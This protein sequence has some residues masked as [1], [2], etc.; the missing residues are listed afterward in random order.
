MRKYYQF[1]NAGA[2]NVLVFDWELPAL[3][4]QQL[5]DKIFELLLR[6]EPIMESISKVTQKS[7]RVSGQSSRRNSPGVWGALHLYGFPDIIGN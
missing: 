4:R 2:R 5:L 3:M 7:L 6:E 1:L